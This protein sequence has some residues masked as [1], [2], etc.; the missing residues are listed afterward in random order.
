MKD[1]KWKEGLVPGLTLDTSTVILVKENGTAYI[2][3]QFDFLPTCFKLL[4]ETNHLAA[5]DVRFSL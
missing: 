4:K 5:S 3:Y 1:R 2:M